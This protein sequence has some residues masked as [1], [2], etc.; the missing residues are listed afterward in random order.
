[1]AEFIK[2]RA[3]LVVT[4]GEGVGIPGLVQHRYGLLQGRERLVVSRQ[5][6][7]Y[8]TF[9]SKS[10]GGFLG[11]VIIAIDFVCFIDGLESLFRLIVQ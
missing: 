2:D 5:M 11:T 3:H 9:L 6:F 4:H 7:Q 1:M 10:D 8:S